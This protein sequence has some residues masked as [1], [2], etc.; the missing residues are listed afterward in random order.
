MDLLDE[1]VRINKP[2]LVLAGPGMGK[3]QALAYKIKYLAKDLKVHKNEITVITFTNEA[4][5]NMRKRISS[6]GRT[7]VEPE[8]QPD[9]I[10]TIH[11]LCNDIIKNNL[12][13]AGLN[14][15]F[16]VLSSQYLK[17]ILMSDCAQIAGGKR[18]NSKETYLCRQ[19][20]KCEETESL[21][22]SICSAYED[23]LRKFNYIDYDDQLLIACKLLKENEEILKNVQ[24]RAKYLLVDE[25]QDINFVQWELIH[26]LTK[27]NTKNLFVV[28]DDYQSIYGFRGGDPEF[29]RNFKNDYQPDAE[30]RYL[31]T[32]YRCPPNIFKGAFCMVY[33][34]NKGDVKR[35]KNLRFENKRESLIKVHNF[36]HNNIEAAFIAG[37]I[38]EIG[39]SYDVLI[40]VPDGDYIPPIKY[41]LRKR[42]V[43]FLCEYDIERTELFIIYV[44]LDW[45]KNTG[46][47]FYFRILLEE[48]INKGV[49]DIP[50]LQTDRVGR[51]E[52]REKREKAFKQISDLWKEVGK[53]ETL[54]KRLKA[55]RKDI[56]F[57]KLIDTIKKLRD[58]FSESD[59]VASFITE[60]IIKLKVW[61]N[62]NYFSEELNSVV[63]EFKNLVI[64]SDCNVRVLTMK[65]AKGLQTDYVFIVGLENNI[66]PC[67]NAD[68]SQK[69]EDSRLLYV[70]MTRAKKEL[71]LLHSVRRDR[72]IT[73]VPI[74][75]RSEFVDAIPQKF[76]EISD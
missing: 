61:R 15:G 11:K 31:Q 33:K 49:S 25:Y 73:K 74:G 12:S 76:M 29:I 36:D 75:D 5:Q 58:A 39:P 10:C 9:A 63:E 42:Y 22:C 44:L 28:G 7:Y 18:E 17:K 19:M 37:K 2:L 1:L 45:L 6:E 47:N 52:N 40:L 38:K 60:V 16:N 30:I 67:I 4:A 48:I 71:Y 55:L 35:V 26:F 64:S 46:D 24:L 8:L 70:S 23:L 32:S 27:G 3:T 72:N 34:Y 66:L 13:E 62:I 68:E 50:G 59:D 57:T 20:G 21:K 14:S 41:A 51:K 69:G 43:N 56:L 65:K 54:Y 53:G